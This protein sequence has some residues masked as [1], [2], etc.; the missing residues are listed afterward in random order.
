MEFGSAAARL[1]ARAVAPQV[2]RSGLL[3]PGAAESQPAR[4]AHPAARRLDAQPSE[5]SEI[6]NFKFQKFLGFKSF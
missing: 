3:V 4:L 5:L 6:S 2:A 1:P